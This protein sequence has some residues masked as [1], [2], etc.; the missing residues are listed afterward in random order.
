MSF[1]RCTIENVLAYCIS[2][3]YASCSAV[4]KKALQKIINTPQKITGWALPLLQ[5]HVNVCEDV[6]MWE[7]RGGLYV[8]S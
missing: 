2:T 3:W 6:G 8:Y 5:G 4:D 7:G 1:C